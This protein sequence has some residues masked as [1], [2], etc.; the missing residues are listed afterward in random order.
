MI[1][2]AMDLAV[3][4]GLRLSDVLGLTRANLTEDGIHVKPQKTQ[5]SSGV[6]LIIL[7]SDELREV[8]REALSQ[9]PQVRQAIICTRTGKAYTPNGF[10]VGWNKLMH[11]HIQNGGEWFQFRD[12]RAK[13]ASDI[14]DDQSLEAAKDLLGH[15]A[16]RITQRV[17]VRK[18]RRVNPSN[19]Q[20]RKHVETKT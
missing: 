12:L 10:G 6:D 11:K 7:W 20:S 13:A 8:I 19:I 17:Y 5:H 18:P 15:T 3:I 16:E 9:R 1:R 14:A 4:T 2:C